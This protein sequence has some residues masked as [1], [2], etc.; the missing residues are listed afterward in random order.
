MDHLRAQRRRGHGM[1]LE[2]ARNGRAS[3]PR[4]RSRWGTG[5]T[6]AP[7]TSRVPTEP[8]STPRLRGRRSAGVSNGNR[9]S[10]LANAVLTT[11]VDGWR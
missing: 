11:G 6:P 8:G 2:E 7:L 1:R 9:D 10:D 4:Y 5:G 3:N